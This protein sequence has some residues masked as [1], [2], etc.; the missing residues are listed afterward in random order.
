[1]ST[2]KINPKETVKTTAV[3]YT[4][5]TKPIHAFKTQL[6]RWYSF[7]ERDINDKRIANQL[8]ILSDSVVIN[9]MGNTATSKAE[10]KSIAAKYKGTKNSHKLISTKINQTK[11][12]I[13]ANSQIVF[14]TIR[15]DGSNAQMRI[16]YSFETSQYNGNTLPLL[17]KIEINPLEQLSF[18]SFS[19]TYAVNR[20][21]ALMHFWLFNIEQMDGNATP[22]KQL[23]ADQFELHFSKE[24]IVTNL[25]Q[26]EK[27]VK[28]AAKAVSDTN[29]FPENFEV[30]KLEDNLYELNVDFVWRGK[31]PDNTKLKAVTHHKW[32][33]EDDI[34]EP[35]AKI[36]KMEV[37]YKVP[38]SPLDE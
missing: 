30:T 18:N 19:D 37:S 27:W 26:F 16:G 22:F 5:A 1:M 21:S 12:A 13:N 11:P 6:Y 23:L 4:I 33:V 3:D 36:R 29:H 28:Y 38:F 14:Q 32:T 9:S 8:K 15:P 7:Y 20:L 34:N 35:F 24:T 31:S 17:Q 25:E 10:Y 2:Q